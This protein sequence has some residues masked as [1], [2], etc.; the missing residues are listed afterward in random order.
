MKISYGVGVDRPREEGYAVGGPERPISYHIN[1][2]KVI[3]IFK[4][5]KYRLYP[6]K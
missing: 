1:W 3:N 5:Y 6:N 4:A 2:K